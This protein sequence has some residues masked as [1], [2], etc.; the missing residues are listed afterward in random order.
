MSTPTRY[1]MEETAQRG[2]TMY[3][4]DIRPVVEED[5]KGK[6]V[7]IN[8]ES[9][10]WEMHDD[11]LVACDRLREKQPDAEIWCVRVGYPALRQMLS[12]R[13]VHRE[14]VS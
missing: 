8:I 11:L 2:D 13:I 9:G 7:A 1:S 10:E 12:P 14:A 6:V 5:N 3:E 4:R